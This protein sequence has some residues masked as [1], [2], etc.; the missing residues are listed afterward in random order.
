MGEIFNTSQD[1]DY[2]Y[3]NITDV[4]DSNITDGDSHIEDVIYD[5]FIIKVVTC[6]IACV[7]L[8]L[9]LVAIYAL[10]SMV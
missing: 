9:T 4:H 6:I 3:S 8:P 5:R 10:Y 7:G 2:D 1:Y